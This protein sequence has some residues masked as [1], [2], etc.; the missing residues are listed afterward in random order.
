MNKH[1]PSNTK[2][3]T[4]RRST[5]WAMAAA[6]LLSLSGLPASAQQY[7]VIGADGKVTYTDRPPITLGDRISQFKSRG[8]PLNPEA[9]LP[10]DL[11]QAAQRYPV[12][13]YVTANCPPC[14]SARQFLRQRGIPH[15]EKSLITAE[16]GEALARLTG[17]RDAPAVTIGAQVV[18]GMSAE[19]WTSY[20]DAAGYPKE[21]KL[22][23][24]Y[25][26]PA[27]TP[28]TERREVA[29]EEASARQPSLLEDAKEVRPYT[30]PGSG[31]PG[32]SF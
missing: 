25:Q 16:D 12:T 20:L 9:A 18:R 22:P 23:A 4:T 14:D 7:K 6:T 24:S 21:S 2:S 31:R 27:A 1:S 30:P 5:V 29:R 10:A 13:L 11:R 28:L 15:V 3:T 32:F 8:S 19:S 17:G 26:F